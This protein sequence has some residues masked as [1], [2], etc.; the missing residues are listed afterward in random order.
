MKQNKI[1]I[2]IDPIKAEIVANTL[3]YYNL[4]M[5]EQAEQNDPFKDN[6]Y[7]KEAIKEV[8]KAIR[9]AIK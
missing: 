9:E 7:L 5:L 6:T 2:E 1:K 8:V 3:E 4:Y